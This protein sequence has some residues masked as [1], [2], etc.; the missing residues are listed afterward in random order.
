[1]GEGEREGGMDWAREREGVEQR[2]GGREWTMERG[3]EGGSGDG[4]R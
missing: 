4:E 1:M 2:E 3:R